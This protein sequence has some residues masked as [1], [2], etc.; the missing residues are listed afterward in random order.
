MMS[1]K[2]EEIKNELAEMFK[3]FHREAKTVV[4]DKRPTYRELQASVSR[5]HAK[6]NE[7]MFEEK[8]VSQID[9]AIQDWT[10]YVDEQ[11]LRGNQPAAAPIVD[12]VDVLQMIA[13]RSKRRKYGRK[14]VFKSRG[15]G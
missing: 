5:I 12:G 2:R 14:E 1:K 13:D 6:R 3:P 8:P 9:K 7:G 4:K 11:G 15:V 10:E